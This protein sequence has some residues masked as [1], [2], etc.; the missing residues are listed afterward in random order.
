MKPSKS[1]HRNY[2]IYTLK[3]NANAYH[4]YNLTWSWIPKYYNRQEFIDTLAKSYYSKTGIINN[5]SPDM[6]ITREKHVGNIIGD[7]THWE[8][9]SIH[10]LTQIKKGESININI[11][12]LIGEIKQ[13]ADEFNIREEKIATK[14]RHQRKLDSI[15]NFRTDPV[16]SIH[17]YKNHHRGTWY[18]HPETHQSK[19]KAFDYELAELTGYGWDPKARNLPTAYDDICRHKDKSWKTSCKVKKQWAKHCPKHVDTLDFN[20]KQY[21]MEYETLEV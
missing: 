6:S 11:N 7:K 3:S 1:K 8:S 4:H 19:S 14:R 10:Y 12:S 13:R 15:Y 16:P 9:V 17:N 18:R 20:R 21:N 2:V 5:L